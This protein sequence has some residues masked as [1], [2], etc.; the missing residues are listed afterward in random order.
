M[1]G[2]AP[3]YYLEIFGET[4]PTIDANYAQVLSPNATA[5]QQVA[6]SPI[7]EY[8]WTIGHRGQRPEQ[9][10]LFHHDETPIWGELED[11]AL[12]VY[13]FFP[14]SAG[15]RVKELAA[16]VKYLS[17]VQDQKDISEK[18]GGDWQKFSPFLADAGTLVTAQAGAGRRC[19]CSGGGPHALCAEQA[20]DR[21]GA[22]QRR[23][24]SS[25]TST[26]SRRRA[27][28]SAD[29]GVLQASCG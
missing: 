4:S 28:S 14:I 29:A 9:H 26:R 13:L 12:H 8:W 7:Y 24:A 22:V 3:P 20:P 2:K 25:G 23:R 18:A 15:W 16:T 10:H 27:T 17:P 21:H 19:G 1:D 6:A 5:A 11:P